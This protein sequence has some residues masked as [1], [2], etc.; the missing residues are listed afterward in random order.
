MRNMVK[1]EIK[2]AKKN[3]YQSYFE[4]YKK[5][6]SKIWEGIRSIVNINYKKKSFPNALSE[7]DKII[8]DPQKIANSFN[9]FFTN[10][11]PDIAKKIPKSS[12]S[13]K[14]FLQKKTLKSFYFF[15]T[16]ENEVSKII[17][18]FKNGK[19]AGPNS[20]PL[21]I[22]KFNSDIL[23]K[24]LSFLINLSFIKGK[25]PSLCKISKVI[26]VFKKGN[27]MECTNYR[28]ISLLST[29]SKIF[30][31]CVHKRLY[32]YLEKNKLIFNRQFGFRKGFSTNHALVDLIETIKDHIDKGDYVCSVFIDLRKAFDTVD[33]QILLDKL[34]FYGIRGICYNWFLSYLSNRQ[35]YVSLDGYSSTIRDIKCGVPQ[36]STLGPLLF[37]LYINDLHKVFDKALMIHFAD[38]TKLSFANKKLS[39]IENVMNYEL[40]KLVSWLNC[41]KLSLNSDKTINVYYLGLT[42]DEFLSWNSHINNL[43]K[44]LAQSNGIICKLRHLIPKTSLL[45]VYYSILYSHITYGCLVWQFTSKSN[46]DKVFIFQK[47][48]LRI[49]CFSNFLE[50]S[51]SLFVNLQLL[52]VKDLFECE[53][54]KFFYYYMNKT[55]PD[56]L[57]NK[58][59]L[60]QDFHQRNT[61]NNKLIYIP[62]TRTSR[63]GT[64]SLRSHGASIWNSFFIKTNMENINSFAILKNFLKKKY[65]ES[66]SLLN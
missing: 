8:K 10:I 33:H 5:T 11:G 57:I 29:F 48:C 42:I 27:R 37:L 44:K 22:L 24:P 23:S 60:V 20:I 59:I 28:P 56:S 19:S 4:K 64:N 39:T 49:I 38:D 21:H 61:R 53:V 41:N 14:N 40:K 51:N 15:P 35:Q 36:G 12:K 43:C 31:K 2:N 50:H 34:N 7:G 17:N 45:Q 9:N 13:Y 54:I 32:S 1:T 3:Y 26:P 62:K 47:K 55:L 63:F 16:N 18:N 30:E 66:Y 65:L 46:I 52:K 6:T 25:F 58:F